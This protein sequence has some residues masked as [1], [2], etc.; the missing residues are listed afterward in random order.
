MKTS[1]N[2]SMYT[3]FACLILFSQCGGPKYNFNYAPPYI[4]ARL[5]EVFPVSVRETP[6]KIKKLTLPEDF[7]GYEAS[8]VEGKVTIRVIKC[9]GED[10]ANKY[11]GTSIVDE[12]KG[13]KNHSYDNLDS[14]WKATAVDTDGRQWLA[15]VNEIWIFVL[16]GSDNEYFDLVVRACRFVSKK[17]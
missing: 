11:F 10:D 4:N 7:L 2:T 14:R 12:F 3:V 8:Y 9:P 16:S 6:R 1:Y 5:D 15:W 13:K 17:E